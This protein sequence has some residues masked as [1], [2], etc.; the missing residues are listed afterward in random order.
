V[1]GDGTRFR[2]LNHNGTMEPYEDPRLSAAQRADD[3]VSRLSLEE[4]AGLLFHSIIGVG[5]PG[6]Y[7]QP[8]GHSP[9]T[10][11]HLV[12]ERLIN[13]FNVHD[14]PAP[15]ITAS[16][17]NAM[18]ELAEQTP[19]GIP[20]T[21]STD[22]RHGFT[23]N[24]GVAFTSGGMSQWPEP[25]GLAAIGDE[26]LIRRFAEVARKE[27]VAVGIRMSLHPQ[28]DLATEPRWGRQAQTFGAS[29]ELAARFGAE[30]ISGMQ[31]ELGRTSV[32]CTA[33]HFP[34]G[35]PQRDGEDP[36][37]PYGREQVYPGGRFADHLEPFRAVI[38]AGTAAIMP[39]YGMPVGLMIDGEPVEQVGFG[40]N[41]P[42][43]TGLLRER[44]GYD[45]VVLTDWGLVT[46]IVL[47]GKPF[48]ARAWGVE[49]LSPIDRVAKI[50]DAGCDQ[51][52]GE[53][54]TELVIDLVGSGR[55][56][57]AR[58]DESVRRILLLKFR[59]GLFDDPY[60]DENEA[61]NIV[62]GAGF[63]ADGARAQ[64]RSVT[65]L[66][67]NG[68]LPLRPGCPVFGIGIDHGV[69]G[70]F[71]V[72]FVDRPADAEVALV[73]LAAPFEPRDQ[74]FLEAMFHQGSLEFPAE[75]VETVRRLATQLPVVVDVSCD[76]PAIL[77]P[78]VD[79]AA[80]L[81]VTYGCS[82]TALID[83]LTGRVPNRGRLPFELPR[84]MAAV[85]ASR[86]DVADDTAD[87]L[88]PAGSGIFP[89][90]PLPGS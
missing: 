85:A 76:R 75:T 23:R 7:D 48:P 3:L 27:Y 35:G 79:H 50:L 25:L 81:V 86:P 80:A 45:G 88:F 28:I 14:L 30:F 12:D 61:E 57:T 24:T 90:T 69:G 52:G 77:T 44:L 62:G 68:I 71:G 38:S 5:E 19:H 15:G 73:R 59:L 63:V 82:D 54:C 60:V 34:G 64:S 56:L 11:R 72:E 46:D 53:I 22:P 87:A 58:V 74:Y 67:D 31:G 43:I 4:K 47:G 36:H 42:I 84:S 40:F 18:Q 6:A 16:W 29:S 49:A 83:A 10:P 66:S 51:F 89:G 65:V 41:R 13:H 26:A 17:Q 32:A 39:Y 21:F 8:A 20:I 78:L 55:I 70:G 2:D 33:K 37:F 9:F 1:S